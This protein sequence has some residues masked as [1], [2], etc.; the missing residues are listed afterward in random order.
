M[1][2]YDV[3]DKLNRYDLWRKFTNPSYGTDTFIDKCDGYLSIHRTNEVTISLIER[4]LLMKDFR[5]GKR[6]GYGQENR[7]TR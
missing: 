5:N 7:D 1:K 2:H 6:Y 3:W 4:K